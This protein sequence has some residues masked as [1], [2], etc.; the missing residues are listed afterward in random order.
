MPFAAALSEHPVAA[1]ATGEV[2]GTVL[3]ALGAHPDLVLVFATL[4][5]AGALEDI[6]A[7]AREILQPTVILGAASE[8]VVGP[9]R[10]VEGD[11]AVVLW[12]GRWGPVLPVRFPPGPPTEVPFTPSALLLFGEPHSCPVDDVL[13]L[14]YPVFGGMLS[15][16][17]RLVLD[18]ALHTDGAVGAL[19]GPGVD[20][21]PV[22]SQGCRPVGRPL[23]VTDGSSQTIR[24][25]GGQPALARVEELAATLSPA[26]VHAVNTAGLHIGR[27]IDERKADFET[28]DFLVRA[29]LGV[30]RSTG[31]IVVNDEIDVGTTV[32]FHLRDAT[33]AHTDLDHLLAAAAPSDPQAALVFT[34]NG[35]GSRLFGQPDHDAALVA[36]RLG[37]LPTAGFAAAGELGPVIGRNEFHSFTASV[38]L[39][40]E[41]RP[42]G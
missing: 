6:V 40:R 14:P 16:S 35:R 4:P 7:T 3:E 24:Q 26:E 13:A 39:L 5:H 18:D 8:S 21:I 11:A 2:C 32:Q 17:R 1:Y 42:A 27:V 9:A 37:A 38:L 30:D 20:V 29:V 15:G 23:V 12:A 33:A 19:L 41:H 10:E 36:S 25:L 31:A 34:C 28:G 22:V